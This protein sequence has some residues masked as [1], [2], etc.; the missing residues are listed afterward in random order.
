MKAATLP[1]IVRRCLILFLQ[2][3]ELPRDLIQ[4]LKI[5]RSSPSA[6]PR[7]LLIVHA[8]WAKEFEYI[9]KKIN[10]ISLPLTIQVTVPDGPDSNTIRN[11]GKTVA[12]RHK[13]TFIECTNSGRDIGPFL[14]V[15]G[16]V[17]FH[18]FTMIIKVH[19]KRSQR[20]WFESL[21][22]SLLKDEKRIRKIDNALKTID[23]G[24]VTHPLSKYP[25]RLLRKEFL[26]FSDFDAK[27]LKSEWF[28]PAGSMYAIKPDL[29]LDFYEVW[30][31]SIFE[32]ESDYSQF[33][34]AHIIERL[35]GTFTYNKGLRIIAT[36]PSDYLDIK[37]LLV[38]IT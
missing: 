4:S 34:R 18:D 7:V 11:L 12:A 25:G 26:D 32:E 24:I 27:T 15:L 23:I 21:V 13:L 2:V 9:L 35:V 3:R 36:S 20:F 29:A 8:F 6:N 37:G 22:N 14:K 28:F 5:N 19:T 10:K 16:N 38:K 1:K 30:K 33:T 17:D 31:D